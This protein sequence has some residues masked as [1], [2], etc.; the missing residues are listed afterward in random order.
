ML[1]RLRARPPE[2]FDRLEYCLPKHTP[3][4]SQGEPASPLICVVH[5]VQQIGVL[6][7][8]DLAPDLHAWRDLTLLDGELAWQDLELLDR[9]PALE[10]F[11]ACV[12][13]PSIRSWTSWEPASSS[14]EE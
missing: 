9:F 6:L 13:N 11:V 12:T 2:H 10:L 8:H 4:A 5:A 1:S 7:L 14:T 3:W